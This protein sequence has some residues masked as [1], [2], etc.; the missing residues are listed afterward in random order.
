MKRSNKASPAWQFS[1]S[2][3]RLIALSYLVLLVVLPLSAIFYDGFREGLFT[4]LENIL[5]PSAWAALKLSLWTA[6]VMAL[7]NGMM[8]TLTAYVLV[9]YDFWGKSFLNT[10]VD[11][12]FA[13][14][15]LVT[16]VMLVALY[17]PEGFLGEFLQEG[18]GLRI[19]FAPPAI[20]IALLFINFPVVVRSVQPVL[21]ELDPSQEEAA[22]T[23]GA[24]PWRIFR[25]VIFPAI[26][27]ATW[28]GVLLSFARA[29]GEFGAVVVVAGNLP[30]FSQTAA[31]YVWGEIE[32]ENRLGASAMSIVLLAV[33]F[34]LVLLVDWLQT[35]R[36]AVHAT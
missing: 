1:G 8:G 4:F 7:F 6:A 28:T 3:L 11:L 30:L 23:L 15:S 19:L 20:V 18:L 27:P 5:R 9:R 14:P 12:P 16:G 26:R 33:S 36:R 10:I 25:S 29:L 31:V 2:G 17:G 22:A 24:S 21:E 35:R 34:L 13:I 32:S